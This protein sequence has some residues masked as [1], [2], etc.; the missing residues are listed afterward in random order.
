MSAPPVT[1]AGVCLWAQRVWWWDPC[2]V[3]LVEGRG[4]TAN[5][6]ATRLP[7]EVTQGSLCIVSTGVGGVGG[8][9]A[10]MW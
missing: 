7:G 5:T 10:G 4:G 1:A 2:G 8:L 6:S 9:Y 3:W